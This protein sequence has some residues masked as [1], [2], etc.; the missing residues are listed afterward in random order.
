MPFAEDDKNLEFLPSSSKYLSSVS[1]IPAHA[2]ATV[3]WHGPTGH[4]YGSL[5]DDDTE[6]PR[7]EQLFE[8]AARNVIDPAT[9][10]GKKFSW[11][12]PVTKA[13]VESFFTVSASIAHGNKSLEAKN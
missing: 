5:V 13:R 10:T 3:W 6:T 2:S 1:D 9:A 4:F 7:E 8:I 12:V 11:G